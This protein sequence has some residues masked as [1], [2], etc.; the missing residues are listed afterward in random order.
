M[1]I[2]SRGEDVR[3]LQMLLG[4]AA[5]GIFGVNTEKAV[6][7]FQK[8]NGLSRDGIVGEKTLAALKGGQQSAEIN[9][10]KAPLTR[11]FSRRSRIIKYIVVHYTAGKSSAEGNAIKTRN[12][13]QNGSR[14]ASADFVVDDETIVQASPDLLNC[15][16][17]SVGDGDG[18]CGITNTNSVNIEMCSTLKSG[19]SSAKPN[20]EGWC[21]SPSVLAKTADLV[22][23]LMKKYNVPKERVLRH[24]DAS[25]KACPGIVGWNDSTLYNTDGT[26][27][28]KKNNSSKWK[29]WHGA[30]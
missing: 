19:T 4:I 14:D 24:Y 26:K 18:K 8:A 29:E 16:C 25:R 9:I 13:W 10:V 3:E 20:H 15:V 1:K 22:R 5:D 23:Y 7:A 17:W 27:T 28:N 2:G 11:K 30:L 12:G 21:I 6:L